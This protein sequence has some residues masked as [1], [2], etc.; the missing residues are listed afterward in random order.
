MNLTLRDVWVFAAL[1]LVLLT[2]HTASGVDVKANG[3]Q[4]GV[5]NSIDF[6]N[7]TGTFSAGRVTITFA[8]GGG[9]VP[10]WTNISGV[11]QPNGVGANTNKFS[12]N[13]FG[14]TDIGV[15]ASGSNPYS[16]FRVSPDWATGNGTVFF[17]AGT[18][19]SGLQGYLTGIGATNGIAT[20]QITAYGGTSQPWQFGKVVEG[21]TLVLN[22][23]NYVE[24]SVN[25]VLKKLALAQ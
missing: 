18:N 9:I 2:I 14:E 16:L 8:G 3:V 20:P 11:L 10:P 1:W 15:A 4:I 7:S 6:T 24:V 12:I 13:P 19:L 22:A 23:T 21:Q 25:G 5:A 17:E